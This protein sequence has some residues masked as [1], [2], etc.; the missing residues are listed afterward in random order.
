MN[1]G[2]QP[3]S[4][5]YTPTQQ[6]CTFTNHN[7]H[8]GGGQGNG[9]GFPQQPTMNYG[10]TG[11][12]ELQN[13]CSPTNPYK[14]WDNWNYCHS[15]GGD[16]DDNHTSA[17]CGKPSPMH[18]PNASRTNIMGGSVAGMHKFILPLTSG[19]TPPNRCPQQQQRPQQCPPN[20]Y[21]PPGG[22]AWQQPTPPTQYGGMPQANGTFCPQTTMAMLVYQPGQGMMMNVGQYPQ[23][24]GIMPMMQM[25]QQPMT[26]PMVMN[27]Y[28]PNQQP[29]QVPWYF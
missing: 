27:H 18:N 8:N 15:H 26:A 1:V 22:T 6:Q 19:R 17:T 11:G 7:K 2:Q 23:S 21:Y 10:G 20:A 28:A 29:N 16:V 25:G 3:P 14:W 12:G 13:I 24:A 4:S 9:C 5:T